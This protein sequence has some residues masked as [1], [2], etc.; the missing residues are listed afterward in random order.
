MKKAVFLATAALSLVAC[1]KTYLDEPVAQNSIGFNTW[2][3]YLTKVRTQG[4]NIFTNGDDFAVYGS[5]SKGSTSVIVFD[6]VVVST[7]D[8]STWAYTNPKYW[9]F[10]YEKYTF[11]AVSPAS[12]G[13]EGTVSAVTGEITSS[14]ITFNGNDNDILVADKKEVER[15]DNSATYFNSYGTVPMVFN[16]IASLVDIK[17]KKDPTWHDA[18]VSV[19]AFELSNIKNTGTFSVND[20]YSENHPVVTWNGVNAGSYEPSDGVNPVDITSPIV[21]AEDTDFNPVTPIAPAA[22]TF[23]INNLVVMPQTFVA[24]TGDNPQTITLSY[25]IN[26]NGE[27]VTFN[28]KILYL[29]DFDNVNDAAQDDTK[30]GSWEPGKHYT[31]YITIGAKAITFS[32]SIADWETVSGYNYLVY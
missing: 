19:T 25:K 32:A 8:G 24:S 22:A 18:T 28:D 3:N 10:G 9:D 11:F 12:V 4:T 26:S 31:F 17:V 27:E 21:I 1:G 5:K 30:I 23:V 13:T 16:H 14:S 29:A 20:A 15:G 7:K 6:D 2:T